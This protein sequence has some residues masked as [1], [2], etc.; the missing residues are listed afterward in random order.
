MRCFG[1]Y[2]RCRVALILA[3]ELRQLLIVAVAASVTGIIVTFLVTPIITDVVDKLEECL[4][5]EHRLP[6]L[7]LRQ[8]G[9]ERVRL[10]RKEAQLHHHILLPLKQRCLTLLELFILL[11]QLSILLLQIRARVH[12]NLDMAPAKARVH[13]ATRELRLIEALR[14]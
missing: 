6:P 13:A 1:C 11:L 7:A 3:V 8:M 5:H 9:D 12:V 10:A 4:L 14:R 2:F